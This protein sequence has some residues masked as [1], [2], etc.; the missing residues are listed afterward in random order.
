MAQ[1][2]FFRGTYKQLAKAN[3]IIPEGT[4]ILVTE[5]PWYKS[6]FGLKPTRLKVSDGKT[7]FN[8]LNFI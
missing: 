4:F 3:L 1:V 5:C 6:W 8:K 7:S 2:K